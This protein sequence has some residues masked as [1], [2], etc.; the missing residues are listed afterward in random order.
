MSEQAEV[1]AR[2]PRGQRRGR[3]FASGSDPRRNTEGRK[4]AK[5]V[6]PAEIACAALLKP[7]TVIVGGKRKRRSKL[8]VIIDRF[9]G[10]ALQGDHA[11]ARTVATVLRAAAQ[12]EKSLRESPAP[13]QQAAHDRKKLDKVLTDYEAIILEAERAAKK[14]VAKPAK[15]E[16]KR[17]PKKGEPS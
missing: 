5:Q 6:S 9:S 2:K 11:A 15:R 8:E 16:A 7:Q 3:P 14:D 12:I 13:S 10:E 17:P 4:P 1:E